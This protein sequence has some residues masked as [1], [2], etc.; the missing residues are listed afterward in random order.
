MIRAAAVCAVLVL[1]A[2]LAR[3]AG[4]LAVSAGAAGIALLAGRLAVPGPA[5]RPARSRRGAADPDRAFPAYRRI[6]S[7]LIW[8]ATSGRSYD[9]RVR[10]LLAG[11][12]RATL[13]ERH[14]VE[15]DSDPAAARDLLG[16]DLWPLVDPDAR[17][18]DTQDRTGVDLPTITRIVDR[19][20]RM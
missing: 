17:L 4:A 9:G 1:A 11:L 7:E 13:A 16:A 18:P 14:R 5:R 6:R 20:E 10:P 8:A 19:L 2:G 12:L 3:S 15:L